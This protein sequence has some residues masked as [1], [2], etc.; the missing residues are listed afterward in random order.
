MQSRAAL[1]FW[2]GYRLL[3]PE[4]Q[5]AA[6]KQYR[7]WLSDHGHHSVQFKKVQDYW[8]ARVTDHYRALGIMERE[9]VI[10]FWIG[11]HREYEKLIRRKK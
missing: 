11:P 3:P 6:V 10:W 9:T 1:S 8:A 7:L 2:E 4:I 5:R